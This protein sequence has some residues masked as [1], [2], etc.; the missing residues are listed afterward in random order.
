MVDRGGLVDQRTGEAA[1][2]AAR[3]G[4]SSEAELAPLAAGGGGRRLGRRR[5]RGHRE[6]LSAASWETEEEDGGVREEE[7]DRS[8]GHDP[9]ASRVCGTRWGQPGWHIG[10]PG[11]IC[12]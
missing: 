2:V 9:L 4:R 1:E 7:G 6:E 12:V 5:R 3:G 8:M 11:M 10:A